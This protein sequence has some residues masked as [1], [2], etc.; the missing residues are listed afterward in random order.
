MIVNTEEYILKLN[1]IDK[2]YRKD[3]YNL[4]LSYA[5]SNTKLKIGDTVRDDCGNCFVIDKG[6]A[7]IIRSSDP[8]M[9]YSGFLLTKKMKPRVDKQRIGRFE[10]SLK[11][12]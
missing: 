9:V 3:K 2:K 10:S 8:E 4:A 5:K 6:E 7:R 11:V 12:I 1:E